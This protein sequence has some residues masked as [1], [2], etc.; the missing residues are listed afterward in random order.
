MNAC[1]ICGSSKRSIFKVHFEDDGD[2]EAYTLP[3]CGQCRD[4]IAVVA[5]NAFEARISKLEARL[6]MLESIIEGAEYDYNSLAGAA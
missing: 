6:A 5:K 3:I 1:K 4:I 2:C